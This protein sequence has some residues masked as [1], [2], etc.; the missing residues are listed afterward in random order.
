M[1]I[2]IIGSNHTDSMLA[3]NHQLKLFKNIYRLIIYKLYYK[4]ING[5]HVFPGNKPLLGDNNFK[6]NML[7]P[8][9][10]NTSLFY[11]DYNVKNIK[12]KFLFIAALTKNKGHDILYCFF[13]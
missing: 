13:V 9:G 1:N 7:L 5:L 12:I 11:P 6:Y 8:N 2:P 10:I 4:N 3:F